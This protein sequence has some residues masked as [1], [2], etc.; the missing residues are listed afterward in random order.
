MHAYPNLFIKLHLFIIFYI[1]ILIFITQIH[2]KITTEVCKHMKNNIRWLLTEARLSNLDTNKINLVGNKL[3]CYHLTSYRKWGDY[4][5]KI[6]DMIDN[7]IVKHPKQERSDDDSRAM[8]IVKNLKDSDRISLRDTYDIEEKV[9]MD[10]ISDPYTDTSGFS[11]GGG[12]YHGKGLYTC[13]KFN[14]EI[15]WHYGNICLVF[16]IDISNFIITFEDLA[17]QV[18]GEDWRIKDQLLKLYQ[19]EE[20]SPESIETYKK[21]SMLSGLLSSS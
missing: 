14:P 8:R 2:D 15:A 5:P 20:R 17:K 10:M 12:D 7:P 4:N 19:L 1:I 11:A 9:I 6:Q 3:I 21:V 18:Y 16:E 13:Y